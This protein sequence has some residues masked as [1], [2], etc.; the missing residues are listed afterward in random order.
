MS[1]N[2]VDATLLDAK[3]TSFKVL[4]RPTGSL[5]TA[6]GSLGDSANAVF[7]FQGSGLGPPA[8]LV[9]IYR[10]ELVHFRVVPMRV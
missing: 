2:E 8:E 1:G 4:E 5:A 10:G 9:V 6:G 3:G 7:R